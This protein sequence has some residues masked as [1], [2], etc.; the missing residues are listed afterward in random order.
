MADAGHQ[1]QKSK[2]GQSARRRENLHPEGR[3][4]ANTSRERQRKPPFWTTSSQELLTTSPGN[5]IMF[6]YIF[7]TTLFVTP[8]SKVSF[9]NS[10]ILI[11]SDKVWAVMWQL[12]RARQEAATERK[13]LL[14]DST[15]AEQQ[16][17]TMCHTPEHSDV[18]DQQ[19]HQNVQIVDNH[20]NEVMLESCTRMP[21][22]MDGSP[23]SCK[24]EDDAELC[25]AKRNATPTG[26]PR[27]SPM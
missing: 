5:S 17:K 2:M 13:K 11:V 8:Y 15:E 22:D 21:K 1:T 26:L 3:H 23:I 14:E 16:S 6:I 9:S 27:P 7:C 10:L 24:V 25:N 4:K 18:G 19:M 20:D 12:K